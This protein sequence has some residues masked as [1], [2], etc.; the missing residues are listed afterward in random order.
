MRK[1]SIILTIAFCLMT[2]MSTAM[3]ASN[4]DVRIKDVA[5]V[6]GVRS[7]QLVGYGLVMGLNGTGDSNKTLQTM[8]SL[9]SMLKTFGVTVSAAQMQAKNVA[10]VM[11]TAELPAFVKPGDKIDMTMSSMG[12]AKSLQ[13]GMLLQTPL[14]AANGQVYAVGQGPVSTGGFS[15]SAGGSSQSKN[16]PTVGMTTN[17]AI[18]ERDVPVQLVSNGAITLSLNQPDFTTANRVSNAIDNQFGS[19]SI[20]RD[21]G[22]V[23]VTIPGQYASNLVGF[24]AALEELYVTPDQIAKIIINERTGTIVMGA[25]VSIDEVAVAQG[26][27]SI[28]IANTQNVSQPAP[29]SGGVTTTTNNTTVDVKEDK[30]N[31]MVLPATTNVGDVVN[32][33]NAI[34]ATPRD[35]ISILQAMKAAG[36][37]HAD[38]Q[39]I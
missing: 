8:Q 22:T 26:G 6:Q 23:V 30:A 25:R 20:A 5:K 37:L 27:L 11:V 29:L 36:A 38:L 10:A 1:V 9:A 13:G 31:V 15:A 2:I 7:N 24:V 28:R 14:R 33:L 35:I 16:F 18:V 39:I 34:G 17:G 4:A 12:D 19:I 21:P 32:A 3:A